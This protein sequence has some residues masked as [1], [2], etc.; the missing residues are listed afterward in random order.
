MMN[1][2]RA[3]KWIYLIRRFATEMIVVVLISA[4]SCAG[5]TSSKNRGNTNKQP[6][7]AN[8]SNSDGTVN[9]NPRPNDVDVSTVPVPVGLRSVAW[10]ELDSISYR[11]VEKNGKTS[12]L[13]YPQVLD[14]N[15][16]PVA[17]GEIDNATKLE[18][19]P[20]NNL[21]DCDTSR[22]N[23]LEFSCWIPTSSFQAGYFSI[24]LTALNKTDEAKKRQREAIYE[25]RL[26][27]GVIEL[28]KK[29]PIFYSSLLSPS[30]ETSPMLRSLSGSG[31]TT[32]DSPAILFGFSAA[33]GFPESFKASH[34]GPLVL[35]PFVGN[36]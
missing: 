32:A 29:R 34:L 20:L 21:L 10:N 5:S 33:M 7:S 11:V 22:I 23:A 31:G 14:A 25:I 12:V 9:N 17:A 2:N 18:W 13:F 6:L 36:F 1:K 24:R 19:K 30:R 15:G 16:V 3:I 8:G 26:I 28:G 27:G 35:A 4:L